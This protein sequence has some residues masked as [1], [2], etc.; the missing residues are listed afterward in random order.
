MS[1][2]KFDD[3]LPINIQDL[4]SKRVIEDERIEFKEGWNPEAVLHTLCAFA[5]DFHNLGGG[6]L[7]IGVAEENGMPKMPPIGLQP[8]QIDDIRKQLLQLEKNAITPSFHTLTATYEIQNRLILV[9]WAMAGEM[10]PYRAK[11]QLTFNSKGGE[12]WAY[13]IRQHSSTIEARGEIEQELLTLANKIPFDD[14]MNLSADIMHD[15]EPHL[16]REFL[17]QI[18]SELARHA[19]HLSIEEL[20]K[21]LNIVSGT[22]E[23]LFIKNVG[24]LF[25]N[26]EPEKFFPATQIDVVYFPK[27]AGGG[28]INEKIFKGPIGRTAPQITGTR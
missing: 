16:I 7:V 11:K 13:Y 20:A 15:I 28:I 21:R 24:L 8:K 10:R 4:L 5:N 19:R 27:G 17:T 12:N 14:R 9:I 23:A 26:S 2:L 3:K 6:Y 1:G 22:Q 18:N 25:F